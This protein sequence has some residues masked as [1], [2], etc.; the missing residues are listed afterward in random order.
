VPVD[1]F[2]QFLAQA[3]EFANPDD[4]LAADGAAHGLDG[5]SVRGR[6]M[7]QKSLAMLAQRIDGMIHLQRRFRRQP[8]SEGED[9][10]RLK[11]LGFLRHQKRGVAGDLR[12]I[13]ACRPRDQDLRLR[14][15]Q[16]AETVGLGLQLRDLGA[17]PRLPFSRTN[18]RTHQ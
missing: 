17:Q 10:L 4:G 12:T 7:E 15:Q 14:K 8:G 5:V 16:R 6:E 1:G 2:G 13:I 11:L 3:G 18:P 9:A